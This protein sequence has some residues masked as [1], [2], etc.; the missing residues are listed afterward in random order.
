MVIVLNDEYNLLHKT[1]YYDGQYIIEKQS[2]EEFHKNTSSGEFVIEHIKD[3]QWYIGGLLP[4]YRA[5]D[6][7]NCEKVKEKIGKNA[8]IFLNSAGGSVDEALCMA[9]HFKDMNVDT[10][11]Q[12]PFVCISAC[13]W[14]FLAGDDRTLIGDIFFGIHAPGFTRVS[15]RSIPPNVLV[16]EALKIGH[17]LSKTLEYIGVSEELSDLLI[18]RVPYWK[19]HKFDYLD[20]DD[21][22]ENY[23]VPELEQIANHYVD[24]WGYTSNKKGLFT[25]LLE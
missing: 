19:L 15:Y 18:T 24:F 20:I 5:N 8:V 11:V 21:D 23:N 25:F 22:T 1:I 2:L 3:N 14:M 6:L 9:K 13:V 7:K 10:I 16:H 17:E 12:E 4:A